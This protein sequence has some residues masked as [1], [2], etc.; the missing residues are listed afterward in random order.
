MWPLRQVTAVHAVAVTVVTLR[1]SVRLTLLMLFT[2]MFA[3][4][5]GCHY[6]YHCYHS[7][8]LMPC[9][10]PLLSAMHVPARHAVYALACPAAAA[11]GH[12]H[13][14]T[15]SPLLEVSQL[16][17]LLLTLLL[18]LLLLLLPHLNGDDDPAA[19]LRYHHWL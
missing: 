6:C 12:I 3:A 2:Y 10:L 17:F 18:L 11:D 5:T 19:A 1:A 9:L 4:V 14:T 7:S 15:L 13:T 8:M 16:C